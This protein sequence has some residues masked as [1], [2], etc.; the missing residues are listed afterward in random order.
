ME[1]DGQVLVREGDYTFAYGANSAVVKLTASD[2]DVVWKQ[3]LATALQALFGFGNVAVDGTKGDGFTIT[4]AGD[5]AGRAV[6]GLSLSQPIDPALAIQNQQI[7]F[8]IAADTSI[9]GAVYAIPV[10]DPSVEGNV[11]LALSFN[12][13]ENEI[14]KL[15]ALDT[16]GNFREGVYQFGYDGV[17]ATVDTRALSGTVLD[18]VT[19]LERL[20]LVL[21]SLFG[22][23][24]VSVIGSRINGFDIE[25]I[26]DF[27]GLSV[28]LDSENSGAG[29]SMT[30]PIDPSLNYVLADKSFVLSQ[31]TQ[32]LASAKYNLVIDN[33]YFEKSDFIK[34]RLQFENSP[35]YVDVD[36]TDMQ[37]SQPGY[38]YDALAKMFGLGV[39][40]T[41]SE[42]LGGVELS[43]TSSADLSVSAVQ[44]PLDRQV[45]SIEFKNGLSQRVLGLGP[46]EAVKLGEI[47]AMA[48]TVIAK[49]GTLADATG[50][51]HLLDGYAA[52]AQGSFALNFVYDGSTYSTGPV[53]VHADAATVLSALTNAT[54][55]TTLFSATSA[56]VS[57][58]VNSQGQWQISFSGAALGVEIKAIDRSFTPDILP[59]ATLTSKSLGV[60][61]Y[62][63]V[64]FSSKLGLDVLSGSNVEAIRAAILEMSRIDGMTLAAAG[65]DVNVT[66][67]LVSSNS[68][69]VEFSGV[70]V[71]QDIDGFRVVTSMETAP[72]AVLTNAHSGS[73]SSEVQTIA[74]G[75]TVGAL[76]VGYR[77]QYSDILLAQTINASSLQAALERLST[78][79]SG[80]V[81]V[82]TLESGDFVVSF[83]SDLAGRNVDAVS[84]VPV[85]SIDLILDDGALADLV[86]VKL[87]SD[88]SW[89][90]T[91]AVDQALGV[92]VRQDDLI[93]NL[94]RAIGLLPS[95]GIGNID[96]IAVSGVDG[97]YYLKTM[98]GLSGQILPPIDFAMARAVVE[99]NNYLKI[100]AENVIAY[101]GSKTNGI[102]IND[103]ILA[104]VLGLETEASDDIVA[105]QTGYAL[106]VSGVAAI[107]GFDGAISLSA[108]A[109]LEINTLGRAVE[110]TV[111]T[112]LTTAAKELAF[113]DG[114][115]RRELTIKEGSIEVAGLGSVS[116]ALKV[117]STTETVSGVITATTRI[118]V[119]SA[120]GALT[121]G[122]VGVSLENG[123]GALVMETVTVAEG[124][125]DTKYGFV[126][127]G[128]VTLVGVPGVSL[129][130]D[131]L[132]VA[133]N[134]WGSDLDVEVETA[135]GT[136]SVDL[137]DN[138]TRLRGFMT[139][140]VADVVSAQGNLFMESRIDQSVVLTD[141]T[142]VAVDQLFIG[143]AGVAVTVGNDSIGA[144]LAETDLVIAVSTE[145]VN[146]NVSSRRWLAVQGVV[147]DASL[148]AGVSVEIDQAEIYLNR[149]IVNGDVLVADGSAIDWNGLGN[150]ESTNL[151][152]SDETTLRLTD[153]QE[154]FELA[155]NGALNMGP[156]HIDG[157]FGLVL[158]TDE[159]GGQTWT[160]TVKDAVVVLAANGAK[161]QLVNGLGTLFIAA[162]GSKS[163]EIMGDARL[164]GVDGL[165]LEGSFAARFDATG[166]M[167]LI[168]DVDLA[169]EG[170][171]SLN[172]EFAVTRVVS[173]Q[174]AA[175][176]V[177]KKAI[178]QVRG[179]ISRIKLG[180]SETP[181]TYLLTA[182][183]G[184]GSDARFRE[185]VYVF[186]DEGVS[187]SVSTR[188]SDG[189]ALSD[190][191]FAN[192]LLTG[193][194]TF[195]GAETVEVTGTRVTGF[196]IE[197]V[198]ILNGV[199][200]SGLTMTPP[201][202]PADKDDWGST[203]I[204]R[205]ALAEKNDER[206]LLLQPINMNDI[207]GSKFSLE[208]GGLG[209][210]EGIRYI[211]D[212]NRQQS[213]IKQRLEAVVGAGNVNVSFDPATGGVSGQGYFVRFLGQNIPSDFTATAY[214]TAPSGAVL[215][216]VVRVAVSASTISEWTEASGTVQLLDLYDESLKGSF[217]LEFKA[218]G[219]TFTTDNIAFDA[220][221]NDLRIAL[222]GAQ[223]NALIDF[224][225][226][227]GDV[228]AE[229]ILSDNGHQI[230]QVTFGGTTLGRQ[231]P[232]M[233]GVITELEVAPDALFSKIIEGKTTSETQRITLASTDDY[234][235]LSFGSATTAPLGADTSA[236]EIQLALENLSTI[237]RGNVSVSF[238]SV[239]VFDVSF[240]NSLS[241]SAIALLKLSEVQLLDLRLPDGLADSVVL[242]AAGNNQWQGAQIDLKSGNT[243]A[244]LAAVLS[245]MTNDSGVLVYGSE[246]ITVHATSI[247]G[248]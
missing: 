140:A 128:D 91:V 201:A 223:N 77:G 13:I 3:R 100:G 102:A 222:L 65:I 226:L 236:A 247:D 165:T 86:K 154:R 104:L 38:I 123:V 210:V 209:S 143:G 89:Q 68:W 237:G 85:T 176:V 238:L 148:H 141:G 197:L 202:D 25:L 55:G 224:N 130:A 67:D 66:L 213:E 131:N 245:T 227:G 127:E 98:G 234:F 113:T 49:D 52:N 185:G 228:S 203:S 242:R 46:L 215:D 44:S 194:S 205:S 212:K 69:I 155:V 99:P 120:V 83:L 26:G 28:P 5:L 39:G 135:G 74:L 54:N 14:F 221:V 132:I 58:D 47:D 57:V 174:P 220:T 35:R 246:N 124:D 63:G 79:G 193:L 94:T 10:V 18:D 198:G 177:S 161:A 241:K 87:G 218:L 41:K 169:I 64:Y 22:R 106:Q 152:V 162:D 15:A 53:D 114:L 72:D 137:A 180:G 225:K 199:A 117:V 16:N 136:Y 235:A 145:R 163:G 12:P 231:I 101:V 219:S 48:Y 107:N 118:G 156:A 229:M 75:T 17:M 84:I 116:G 126:A 60:T 232:V 170:F 207:S 11:D 211:V 108:D 78:V 7:A 50:A 164:T 189:N 96:L 167:Q 243:R 21:S 121:P 133:Y 158:G 192:S 166:N 204:L 217:T 110:E 32:G 9:T 56:T 61:N 40:A 92:A 27:A 1:S 160:I 146:G 109:V 97:T 150:G 37:A 24:N 240:V 6:T 82:S 175:T 153:G 159:F 62:N 134:R 103:G 184:Y 45:Y 179:T 129:S 139:V 147:G 186:A 248:I 20:N 95:V 71:A 239:G 122:G 105:N 172:G 73:T 34:F 112:G 191:A 149:E 36:Y 195:Y 190:E 157:K 168:G 43:S 93:A 31:A 76:Q 111:K 70:A 80:N 144:N 59:D 2:S 23:G 206:Y 81:S 178:E 214:T 142:T 200:L 188:D 125:V 119:S 151:I 230:W 42:T 171:A 30:A 173:N 33:P 233:T 8:Q 29:F 4:L 244:N 19:L 115:D 88:L 187:V 138:E 216:G 183:Q 90:R 196:K 208:L 182:A 51:I 181:T